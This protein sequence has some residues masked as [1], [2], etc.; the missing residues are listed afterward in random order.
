[1]EVL[2][3]LFLYKLC[4]HHINEKGLLSFL[5][6]LKESCLFHPVSQECPNRADKASLLTAS[7]MLLYAFPSMFVSLLRE[8]PENC[9]LIM[10]SL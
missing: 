6:K 9:V 10:M 7:G 3:T 5:Y 1:M 8:F 2:A 4:N